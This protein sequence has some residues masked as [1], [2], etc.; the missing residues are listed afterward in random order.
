MKEPIIRN[1]DGTYDV[2][3]SSGKYYYTVK[4]LGLDAL[5]CDC[6]GCL[7][8][9]AIC[10]HMRAAEEAERAYQQAQQGKE[11]PFLNAPLNGNR[12]FSLLKP[13]S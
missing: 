11:H 6:K 4:M 9:H 12:G 8:G 5:S 3:S 13:A 2:L 1:E 7:L 10:K